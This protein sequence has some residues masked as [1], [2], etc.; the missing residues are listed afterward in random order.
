VGKPTENW[1]LGRQKEMEDNN[2]MNFRETD[3]EDVNWIKWAKDYFPL[4]VLNFQF[5]FP[6]MVSVNQLVTSNRCMFQMC[7]GWLK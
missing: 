1:P 5:L 2:K 4:V 3:F 7:H 6:E